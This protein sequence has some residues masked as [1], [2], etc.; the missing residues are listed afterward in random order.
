VQ[1]LAGTEYSPDIKKSSTMTN[2]G[3]FVPPPI[4][5]PMVRENSGFQIKC[6]S[7]EI[8]SDYIEEED[9]NSVIR[10]GT[11][12]AEKLYSIKRKA[13]NRGIS[14][15]KIILCILSFVIIIVFFALITLAILNENREY[16]YSAYGLII[17]G[18]VIIAV[19]TAYEA[20]RN[21][22]SEVF[23]FKDVLKEEMSEL[24]ERQNDYF[25]LKGINWSFNGQK[26]QLECRAL[27]ELKA[28]EEAKRRK[29]RGR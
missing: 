20:L 24:C 23:S 27:P 1:P 9:F 12:I 26:F 7:E 2:N 18:F 13:D 22:K 10:M 3:L 11:A 8:L 19:L 4:I 14:R 29:L 21:S 17:A 5:I 28:A 6:Y 16:E 25:K 15:Y